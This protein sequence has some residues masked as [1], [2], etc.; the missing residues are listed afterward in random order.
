M[1]AE[2][3]VLVLLL[4]LSLIPTTLAED[5]PPEPPPQSPYI[6]HFLVNPPWSYFDSSL[7][8]WCIYYDSE[9]RTITSASIFIDN[10][11]Y[12]LWENTTNS[13]LEN[14]KIGKNYIYH[15]DGPWE[16][17]TYEFYFQITSTIITNSSFGYF[18]IVNRPP[19]LLEPPPVKMEVYDEFEWEGRAFDPDLDYITWSWNSNITDSSEWEFKPNNTT[20]KFKIKCENAFHGWINIS[21]W[22]N[23][24]GFDHWNFT[25]ICYSVGGGRLPPPIPR[26]DHPPF[27]KAVGNTASVLGATDPSFLGDDPPRPLAAEV[28]YWSGAV[29]DDWDDPGNWNPLSLMD[30]PKDADDKVYI[31]DAVTDDVMI[32]DGVNSVLTIGELIINNTYTGTMTSALDLIVD[33]SGTESG[34][35]TIRGGTWDWDSFDVNMDGDWLNTG[36]T[37]SNPARFTIQGAQVQSITSDGEAFNQV[38]VDAVANTIY[39]VMDDTEI[40]DLTVLAGAVYEIDSVSEAGHLETCFTDSANCGFIST[41]A[42]TL[43]LQG[44]ATP[45][46]PRL[47]TCDAAPPPTNYWNGGATTLTVTSDYANISY[48][49]KFNMMA[50]DV[51][52]TSFYNSLQWG[53]GLY[54]SITNFDDNTIAS[55]LGNGLYTA[56]THDNFDN[57]YISTSGVSQVF[58]Q[59]NRKVEF[60]NSEFYI[61]RITYGGATGV[62]AVVSDT[63]MDVANAWAATVQA[64]STLLKSAIT[65]DFVSGDNVRIYSGKFVMNENGAAYTVRVDTGATFQVGQNAPTAS[66]TL[67][68]DDAAGAGFDANSAGLIVGSGTNTWEQYITSAATPPT[69]YWQ[70][71]LDIGNPDFTFDYTTL[72]YGSRCRSTGSWDIDHSTFDN[73]FN[74]QYVI[75]IM[76]GAPITSFTHN[77]ISN[78]VFGL[79]T[80]VTHTA[81][82]NIVITMS[83]T[84]IRSRDVRSEFVDSNFDVTQVI[85]GNTGNIIS[86]VHDDIANDYKI[87]ATALAKSTITNDHTGTDNVELITGT[88]TMDEDAASNN[89]W[90]Q[91]GAIL[92]L[93]A[94]TWTVTGAANVTNYGSLLSSGQITRSADWYIVYEDYTETGEIWLNDSDME[95]ADIIIS[96]NYSIGTSNYGRVDE[97]NITQPAGADINVNITQRDFSV[98]GSGTVLTFLANNSANVNTHYTVTNLTSGLAYD[99]DINGTTEYTI[100]A[101]GGQIG[102]N[103]L[104]EGDRIIEISYTANVTEDEEG[105]NVQSP[106]R[107]YTH[108][109]YQPWD[110]TLKVELWWVQMGGP[111]PAVITNR[112]ILVYVDGIQLIGFIEASNVTFVDMPWN[113]FDPDDHNITVMGYVEVDWSSGPAIYRSNPEHLVASNFAKTL[114]LYLI[115]IILFFIVGAIVIDKARKRSD[116]AG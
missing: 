6:K 87:M 17:R 106:I 18:E 50:A 111:E 1:K 55:P 2:T 34:D 7:Y 98:K 113:H 52:D 54:T 74:G 51:D 84:D 57:I 62:Q 39:Y 25:L 33:S 21:I 46:T 81:Y 22:D 59:G 69:N 67:T 64:A 23:Y 45:F 108:S 26:G 70:C 83:T 116:V 110:N 73:F 97:L 89:F 36:T 12:P 90:I 28:W 115:F 14:P 10:I 47:T 72:S 103:Y 58:I 71:N 27:A 48:H 49:K 109:E 85:L 93:N 66:R 107:V 15:A 86:D 88:Y 80:R 30:Y 32:Q 53:A 61:D 13:T 11:S 16:R 29:D 35:I 96:F 112:Y 63:H 44:D 102:F 20:V 104:S 68:F 100:D 42:G 19:Y 8:F 41:S 40:F 78:S 9:N 3:T 76:I 4:L 65:N 95:Y 79:Y 56:V 60:T 43:L 77:T 91:N 101:A 82:D 5:D 99:V 105:D 75:T 114:I 31:N 94:F 24:T 37:I 38:T 92:Q